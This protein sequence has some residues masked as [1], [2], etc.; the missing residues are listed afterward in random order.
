[1]S[2][3]DE[4]WNPLS[5]RAKRKQK[6]DAEYKKSL[7]KPS[8]DEETTE[9]P[10]LEI[11]A[12]YWQPLQGKGKAKKKQSPRSKKK[13]DKSIEQP[14]EEEL[15]DPEPIPDRPQTK[16]A[17]QA[18]HGSLHRGRAGRTMP[19]GKGKHSTRTTVPEEETISIEDEPE[20][21]SSLPIS[22]QAQGQ[23]SAT[24]ATSAASL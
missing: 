4:A 6:K 13:T 1:M 21:V 14:L 22:Q 12:E 16:A 2:I 11:V 17:A 20:D 7:F 24:S 3:A 5:R 19:R 9:T 10:E 18:L 15:A 23:P 8:S